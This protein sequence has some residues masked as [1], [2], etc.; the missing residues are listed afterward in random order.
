[1]QEIKASFPCVEGA[2]EC[3]AVGCA[4][5][6]PRKPANGTFCTHSLRQTTHGDGVGWRVVLLKTRRGPGRDPGFS[7]VRS[8]FLVFFSHL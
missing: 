6:P 2:D 5:A 3:F 7:A 4:C 8:P 1:M